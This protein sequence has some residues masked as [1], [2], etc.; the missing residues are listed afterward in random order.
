MR[1]REGWGKAERILKRKR[2]ATS[3]GFMKAE[4][5]VQVLK[6]AIFKKMLEQPLIADH[7]CLRKQNIATA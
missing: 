4:I 1:S 7:V 2:N 3:T 6:I 5:S